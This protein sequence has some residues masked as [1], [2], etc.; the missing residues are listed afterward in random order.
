MVKSGRRMTRRFLVMIDE[1]YQVVGSVI[2]R[3]LIF[4]GVIEGPR[5]APHIETLVRATPPEGGNAIVS[6]RLS[7]HVQPMS[8]PVGRIRLLTFEEVRVR[9]TDPSTA[10]SNR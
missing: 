8:G 5:L 2:T 9:K 7:L 3:D 6:K 10:S 1:D 4:A